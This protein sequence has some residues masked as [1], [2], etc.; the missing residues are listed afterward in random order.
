MAKTYIT[1]QP[2]MKFL[3]MD[4]RTKEICLKPRKD[5][6]S[7]SKT[8]LAICR[9]RDLSLIKLQQHV[10]THNV[11]Y[12]GYNFFIIITWYHTTRLSFTEMHRC[13][14]NAKLYLLNVVQCINSFALW[15]NS[16]NNNTYLAIVAAPSDKIF[17]FWRFSEVKKRFLGT[18]VC[19]IIKSHRQNYKCYIILK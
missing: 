4:L 3:P 2:K 1:L 5:I 9:S 15:R 16:S 11:K 12:V 18:P 14:M 17:T 10:C 13:S 19:F 6:R 8:N 7:K